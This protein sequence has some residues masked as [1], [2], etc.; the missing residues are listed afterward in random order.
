MKQY[1][2]FMMA[3]VM[4]FSLLAVYAVAEE[5]ATPEISIVPAEW[6]QPADHQGRVETFEYTNGSDI[7]T[8]YVYVPYGY[9]E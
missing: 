8:A 4:V 1:L 2:A 9:D 6:N 5:T 3:V 7:K